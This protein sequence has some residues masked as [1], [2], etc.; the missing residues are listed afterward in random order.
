M[1]L[2]LRQEV[3][4]FEAAIEKSRGTEYSDDVSFESTMLSRT[5]T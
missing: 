4:A 1:Q 3:S 5:E 2:S